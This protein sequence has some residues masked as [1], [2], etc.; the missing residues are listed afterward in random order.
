[1]KSNKC[2]LNCEATTFYIGEASPI[3]GSRPE[4]LSS[5]AC[6]YIAIGKAYSD[7]PELDCHREDLLVDSPSRSSPHSPARSAR[8]ETR[9]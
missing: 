5:A 7:Q 2:E 3:H 4:P 8:F 1:M 9:C 6:A